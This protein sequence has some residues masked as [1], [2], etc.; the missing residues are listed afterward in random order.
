[1]WPEGVSGAD[2]YKRLCAPYGGRVLSRRNVHK[3]TERFKEGRGDVGHDE[4]A[5]R[6][7]TPTIVDN[8]ARTRELVL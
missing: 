3:R 4:G 5:G 7:S 1:M 2:I 8:T 6:P